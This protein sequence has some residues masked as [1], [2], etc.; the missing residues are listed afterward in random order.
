MKEMP[1]DRQAG[2]A[3]DGGVIKQC[4]CCG[5]VWGTRD[6]LLCDPQLVVV[7]YQVNFEELLLGF[8][9]FSHLACGS[10][11]ALP[12]GRFRDLYDGPVYASRATG[13]QDCPEYC[14]RRAELDVCPAQCECAYVREILQIVRRWPKAKGP[15]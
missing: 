8:F 15:E 12:A 9:L 10:T 2:D 3:R 14:L 13:T 4:P 5:Y 1:L 6:A 11:I 7:G